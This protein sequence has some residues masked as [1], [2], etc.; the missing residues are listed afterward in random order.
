M[1]RRLRTRS[2][3]AVALALCTGCLFSTTPPKHDNPKPPVTDPTLTVVTGLVQF[4]DRH[5]LHVRSMP[6]RAVMARWFVRHP[7]SDRAPDV[8]SVQHVQS[9]N[10]GVF[11]VSYR[12]PDL[13]YVELSSIL[14]TFDPADVDLDR[15]ITA[16][17]G[18]PGCDVWAPIQTV[19]VFPGS[20]QQQNLH[21]ICDNVP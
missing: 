6:G 14:C 16:P 17:L 19:D 8:I 12:D 11:Q 21:V 18:T 13:V 15:C 3:V 5:D 4:V 1:T 10:S 2:S 9:G 20:H 7:N